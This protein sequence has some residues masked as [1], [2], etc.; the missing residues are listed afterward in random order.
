MA[1]QKQEMAGGKVVLDKADLPVPQ[2]EEDAQEAV[3][4]P[5]EKYEPTSSSPPPQAASS[6]DKKRK[7]II[8]GGAAGLALLLAG[9]AW[10]FFAPSSSPPPP[11]PVAQ[12]S[13][14]P[15][16]PAQAGIG[17]NRLSLEPF[18]I[19][20]VSDGQ[21]RL[22]RLAVILECQ[23]TQERDFIL[24]NEKDILIIRDAIYRGFAGRSN[25]DLNYARQN[26]FLSDQIM[27]HINQA[28][29]RHVISRIYFPEFL[30]AG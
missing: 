8:I 21:G 5:K 20:L 27:E 12:D 9:A 13:P 10:L 4:P 6:P 22:L 17:L 15:P 24:Q 1:E 29:G 28:L 14:A 3:L 16:P 30:F 18:L 23:N 19:P 25:S 26:N 7:F 11:D 2:E